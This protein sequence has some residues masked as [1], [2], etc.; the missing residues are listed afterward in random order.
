MRI[1]K[2]SQMGNQEKPL[3]RNGEVLTLGR[4]MYFLAAYY[5]LSGAVNPTPM[6]TGNSAQRNILFVMAQN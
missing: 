1:L 3:S 6:P 2:A 4:Q 5:D